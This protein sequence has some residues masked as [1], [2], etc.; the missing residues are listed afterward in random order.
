MKWRPIVLG[1]LAL[2][3]APFAPVI[4]TDMELIYSYQ[5]TPEAIASETARINA[6]P[7]AS[8]TSSEQYLKPDLPPA[9]KDS[10]KNGVIS[11]SVFRNRD[12]Q[13]VYEQ[14]DDKRYADMSGRTEDGKGV[15]AN[16]K[17]IELI[18]VVDATVAEAAV[19]RDTFSAINASANGATNLTYSFTTSGSDRYLIVFSF[20]FQGDTTTGVTYN[21]VA[22]T[23]LVDITRNPNT[24]TLQMYA[25]GLANPT[26]GA[27]NVSITRTGTV[28]NI[29]ARTISYTGV[30]QVTTPDATA[31]SNGTGSVST[32]ITTSITTVANNTAVAGVALQDNAT[33]GNPITAGTNWTRLATGGGS[34]GAAHALFESSTFP[35]TPAGLTSFTANSAPAGAGDVGQLI[36]SLAP[37]GGSTF[38]PWQFFDF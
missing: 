18:S 32:T 7:N 19:A 30:N 15:A 1:T 21:S 22:M 33:A 16:P 20:D 37:A 3:G 28:A 29:E 11:V 6:L 26:S 38:N 36:V 34:N 4:P 14:I 25:W 2:A 9:F 12:G 8:A 27:N 35:L 13:L 5:T 24:G 17:K 10:D 23:K 31:S